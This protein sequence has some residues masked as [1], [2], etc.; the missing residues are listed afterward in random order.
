ME[1]YQLLGICASFFTVRRR[2]NLLVYAHT[3]IMYVNIRTIMEMMLS[4]SYMMAPMTLILI[5]C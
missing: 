5:T 3:I 2:I 4:R 1:L